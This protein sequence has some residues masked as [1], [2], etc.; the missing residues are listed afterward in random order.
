MVASFSSG[1]ALSASE[2]WPMPIVWP[3]SCV[4]TSA[5]LVSFQNRHPPKPRLKVMLPSVMWMKRTPLTTPD[6]PEAQ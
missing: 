5:R 6:R 3:I 4:A 2:L 1:G